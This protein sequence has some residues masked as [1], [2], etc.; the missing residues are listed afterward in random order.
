MRLNKFLAQNT[1]YSRRT[2]DRLIEQG[3]VKINNNLANLGSEIEEADKVYLDDKLITK[4]LNQITIIFNKPIGYICS[5][6]GQGGQTIYEIL[7]KKYHHLKSVGRLDKNSSGLLV[8]TSN[9]DLANQLTHPKYH[10]TK[11]YQVTLDKSLQPLHKQMITDYGVNLEDGV[12]KFVIED[13]D[14][15]DMPK[16]YRIIMQE[17][18]NR[19]I[20][21]TFS[22]LG[23]RVA[24]LHR[25]D[26]GPYSLGELKSKEI[27]ILNSNVADKS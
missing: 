6:K 23:Y 16:K 20:R 7:P 11:I 4:S 26:F 18:R 13:S 3:R 2:S 27:K 17:G 8:M 12:S 10:K 25:T 5:R 9:G 1:D 14:Q 15:V 21:R 19:Q 24:K 22:A